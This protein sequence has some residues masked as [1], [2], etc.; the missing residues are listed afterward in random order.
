MDES[1]ARFGSVDV[2]VNNAGTNPHFGPLVDIS[3]QQMQKTYEVNQS[4]IVTHVRAA[5][6]VW[7]REHGG[8]VLN[9]ASVG[10]LSPEPN[11]GWYNVTKAAV[12]H[13]TKQFAYE[14]A[15]SVRVN[16]LAPGV[17]RTELAWALWEKHEAEI[18]SHIPL[19]R[20][21]EPEDVASIALYLVSDASA[22]VTG[23]TIVV[24]GGTLN[25]PSGGVG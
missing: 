20:L 9:I 10:G 24:D 8:V 7:M 3:D 16:A 23:Q 12:I 22:W 19:G 2:L 17:V 13:L 25:Q 15:P 1:R 18:A 4:S 14:L 21:G 5:W 11:I 6:R